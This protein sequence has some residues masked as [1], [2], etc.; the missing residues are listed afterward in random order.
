MIQKVINFYEF[1]FSFLSPEIEVTLPL[2][3][4]FDSKNIVILESR[5]FRFYV[6]Q[7]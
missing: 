1:G 6:G 2:N 3:L 5:T 7:L 4:S